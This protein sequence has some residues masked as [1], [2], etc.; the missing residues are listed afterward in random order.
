MTTLDGSTSRNNLY[1][2][3]SCISSAIF[4]I[5]W[6][7][8]MKNEKHKAYACLARAKAVNSILIAVKNIARSAVYEKVLQAAMYATNDSF[9]LSVSQSLHHEQ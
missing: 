6:L 8:H 4:H 1:L 5:V 3:P 9:S 7:K 2:K